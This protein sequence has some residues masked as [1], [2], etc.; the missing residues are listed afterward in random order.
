[1][2]IKSLRRMI[3]NGIYRSR[4][5]ESFP[6]KK[7]KRKNR[8][9]SI[10]ISDRFHLLI[11]LFWYRSSKRFNRNSDRSQSNRIVIKSSNRICGRYINKRGMSV[12]SQCYYTLLIPERW[13]HFIGSSVIVRESWNAI[14]FNNNI[15]C[16]P[17]RV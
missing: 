7:R 3:F 2:Y 10:S 5:N 9:A 14:R 8:I 1:M 12:V 17:P 15:E 11:N 6:R 16:Y 4:K 13:K